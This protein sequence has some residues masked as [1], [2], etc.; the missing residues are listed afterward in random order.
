MSFHVAK[1]DRKWWVVTHSGAVLAGPFKTKGEAHE[2]RQARELSAIR[3][4]S[5]QSSPNPKRPP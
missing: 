1:G 2:N 4:E 5:R 3:R